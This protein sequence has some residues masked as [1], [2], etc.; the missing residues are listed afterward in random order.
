MAVKSMAMIR[1]SVIFARNVHLEACVE[2]PP[3]AEMRRWQTQGA[4]FVKTSLNHS[5][6]ALENALNS[7]M[8]QNS[9]LVGGVLGEFYRFDSVFSVLRDKG[10]CCEFELQELAQARKEYM[11]RVVVAMA[12]AANE[13]KN[14]LAQNFIAQTSQGPVSKRN[15]L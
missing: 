12:A 9:E 2:V 11:A 10:K 13:W 3:S 8:E 7:D 14:A 6:S 5:I 4:E 1:P 15:L